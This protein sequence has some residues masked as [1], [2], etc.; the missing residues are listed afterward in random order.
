MIVMP[1]IG[2][3][4]D[5]RP[6]LNSLL[7]ILLSFIAQVII[8]QHV[9]NFGDNPLWLALFVCFGWTPT[10]IL[11]YLCAR[12]C[13]FQKVYIPNHWSVTIISIVLIFVVLRL[14]CLFSGFK[15]VNFD[16]VYAPT[17]IFSILIISSQFG[18]NMIKKMFVELGDKSV[19]M[20][21]IHGLFFTGATRYFYQPYVMVSDNLWLIAIWTVILSYM[22]AVPIKKI[23]EL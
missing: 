23:I 21:F 4:I 19:Y 10:I 5:H 22:V 17:I 9:P 12:Q 11:G 1:I 7:T 13:F 18:N 8:H 16:M 2:R 20:W 14:K 15:I 6:Y 3:L